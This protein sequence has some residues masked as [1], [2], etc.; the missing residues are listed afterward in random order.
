MVAVTG[1]RIGRILERVGR[2]L[3]IWPGNSFG[4]GSPVLFLDHALFFKQPGQQLER[5]HVVNGGDRSKTLGERKYILSQINSRVIRFNLDPDLSNATTRD[6]I[7]LSYYL[8][9]AESQPEYS[10]AY[11]RNLTSIYRQME[12]DTRRYSR[13]IRPA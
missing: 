1:I 10:W 6:T 3:F 13:M 12:D 8:D 2:H 4:L 5:V 11:R 7:N 9:L